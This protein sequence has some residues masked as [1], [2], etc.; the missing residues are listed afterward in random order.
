MRLLWSALIIT[1]SDQTCVMS[2]SRDTSLILTYFKN[3]FPLVSLKN[4]KEVLQPEGGFL[5]V[6][7]KEEIT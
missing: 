3:G 2:E 1:V 5:G 4:L 7:K 6:F